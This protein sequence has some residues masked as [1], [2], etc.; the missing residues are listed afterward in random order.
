[1]SGNYT[2]WEDLLE[3]GEGAV[4]STSQNVSV[5]SSTAGTT[6]EDLLDMDLP[7]ELK[8]L[9][10]ERKRLEQQFLGLIGNAEP[11]PDEER[12]RLCFP[13]KTHT[14]E[15]RLLDKR[16]EK[17]D[18]Q[19]RIKNKKSQEQHLLQKQKEIEK[20]EQAQEE[21]DRKRRLAQFRELRAKFEKKRQI[22]RILKQREEESYREHRQQEQAHAQVTRLVRKRQEE[23]RQEYRSENQ[24]FDLDATPDFARYREAQR[25]FAQE[26]TI[27]KRQEA[28]REEKQWT[29]KRDQQR[30]ARRNEWD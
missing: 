13:V 27:A 29:E 22:Q 19:R 24:F 14:K 8:S 12:K 7:P 25:K 3:E 16:V 20:A 21:L 1:M 2:F 17:R 5:S 18:E 26:A 11:D 28:L 4:E 6:L 23:Y 9:F 10:Q 15:S 30:D